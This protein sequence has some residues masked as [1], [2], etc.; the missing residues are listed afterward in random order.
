V[1]TTVVYGA[2]SKEFSQDSKRFWDAFRKGEF[3]IIV[4]DVLDEEL[5]DAP[6]HIRAS[7]NAL[8]KS[9]IERVK[10][11]DESNALAE[12]YI[13]EGVVGELSL[14]DCR[15]IAVATLANADALVSWNFKHIINRRDGYN[16][17][18]EKLGYPKI[19]ILTPNQSEVNNES[20]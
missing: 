1:D 2:P 5:E 6:I 15:H 12:R 4:S 11:T 8:P 7:F 19:E 17:I 16:S 9:L 14:D 3:V 20:M 18:N 10:S 13:A